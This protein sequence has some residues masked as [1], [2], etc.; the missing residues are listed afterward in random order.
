MVPPNVCCYS[1]C[2]CR[3]LGVYANKLE[4]AHAF[5]RAAIASRGWGAELN[6]RATSY[7][8][9]ALLRRTIVMDA[10]AE[11]APILLPGITMQRFV[12][13]LRQDH[14]LRPAAAVKQE[15]A[16]GGDKGGE[17]RASRSYWGVYPCGTKFETKIGYAGKSRC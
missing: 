10:P 8:S 15:P 17:D 13:E 2:P 14:A 16:S 9:D 6:F 12:S 3:Y 1:L 11:A 7:R 4:A 5:D